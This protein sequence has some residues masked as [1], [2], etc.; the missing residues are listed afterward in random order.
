MN[1]RVCSL[2][3]VVLMLMLLILPGCSDQESAEGKLVVYVEYNGALGTEDG[4]VEK[5][6]EEKFFQDTGM[7]LDLQV[8]AVGTDMIGQKIVTAM[9]DTTQQIDGFVT[10]YGSDAP[11]NSYILD[12]LTM[13]LTDMVKTH[14][15]SYCQSFNSETDPTQSI[16]NSGKM[17]GKLYALS[18]KTRNAG[19]GMLIRKDYMEKTSFD[20]DDYNILNENHKSMSVD[21]FK[22]M[23]VE[24]K[25]NTE[26]E[27]PVVG[28]PWS[29]DYF[30]TSPFGAVGYAE[31]VLDAEGNLIPAY[32]DESY[33]KTLELYRWLQE[34]KLW[35]ENPSNAQNLLNY[36]ISG[37][38]AIYL[39][40]PEV[41]SQI[42]VARQLKEATG[43]DCI[44]IEPLLREGSDT[45]TNGNSRINGAFSGLAIP[46]KSGNSELL[47][48]Y[49]NWL[50]SDVKNYELALY[51]V[52]GVHWNK[53]V[54][55]DGKEYWEYPED[56]KE[57]YEKALPYSGKFCFIEDYHISDLLKNDY[58]EDERQIVD[59][60][61][62]FPVYPSDGYATEGM[63]LPGVPAT[64]RNLR[65]V[66]NA[67]FDEY[68]SMRAYAWSDAA[69]P[70]GQTLSSMWMQMRENLYGDYFAYITYNTQN[71]N[72]I[73]GQ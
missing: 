42:D 40:W 43:V 67:H 46:I 48:K 12:E 6:I 33:L 31:Q 25:S 72:Q 7:K 5:A 15:P 56:K 62:N 11:I 24:M 39:D 23:I 45:E 69:F 60:V 49:I 32:A 63:I 44:F 22:K 27:R 65:N 66:A 19:W 64:E 30:F 57:Q 47:L 26:V 41:T 53:V 34:E 20:P 51:G 2:V 35:T 70:E 1:K 73:T 36:F 17:N 14:A 52:E 68:V 50:Y 18:S 29:L 10:H 4:V 58:T 37:K 9:A 55:E 59:Q 61:R 8:E 71:Y 28:R 21:D 54:D 13:D 38:G 16:Y 3:L